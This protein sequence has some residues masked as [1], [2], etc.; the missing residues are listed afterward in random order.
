MQV[1]EEECNKVYA[2]KYAQN[3][4][5]INANRNIRVTVTLALLN[6]RDKFE[7]K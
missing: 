3:L 2:G 1:F 5:E 6:K 7:C 4:G